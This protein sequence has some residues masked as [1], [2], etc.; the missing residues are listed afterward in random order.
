MKKNIIKKL[1]KLR[2]EYKN[3]NPDFK[4]SGRYYFRLQFVYEECFSKTT[5]STIHLQNVDIIKCLNWFC[6]NNCITPIEKIL[7]NLETNSGN[8]AMEYCIYILADKTIIRFDNDENEIDILYN[9]DNSNLYFDLAEHFLTYR[10]EKKKVIEQILSILTFDG[11]ELVT[12]KFNLK[13]EPINLNT[14]YNDD[15]IKVDKT[16]RD[17]LLCGNSKGVVLLHGL[18]GTGKTSYLRHLIRTV[19]KEIIFMPTDLTSNLTSPMFMAFLLKHKE[20]ILVIEDA[21]KIISKRDGI[22]NSVVSG[23]L[24]L[25]DG[26]LSDVLNIQVVCT[27]NTCLTTID[28]A[29]L[30]KGR[31]LAKYDFGKLT[32]KKATELSQKIGINKVYNSSTKLADVYYEELENYSNQNKKKVIGF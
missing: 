3:Q 14:N 21:E 2:N 27:F 15:F 31:L 4:Y 5:S 32:S 7:S 18:P 26:L 13:S 19:S 11:K 9:E 30:R 23:L 16:I 8:L 1:E 25:T 24:N 6:E 29:L 12:K 17:R 10:L 20:S 22:R 28:E